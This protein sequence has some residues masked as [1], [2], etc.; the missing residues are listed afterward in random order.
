MLRKSG[1]DREQSNSWSNYFDKNYDKYGK[2]IEI[3]NAILPLASTIVGIATPFIISGYLSRKMHEGVKGSKIVKYDKDLEDMYSNI[4]VSKT[5]PTFTMKPDVF[6]AFFYG[7]QSTDEIPRIFRYIDFAGETNIKDKEEADRIRKG[8]MSLDL[9]DKIIRE[10]LIAS[11]PLAKTH[12]ILSHEAGHGLIEKSDEMP[13]VKF[14][15]RYLYGGPIQMLLKILATVYSSY[16][17][18]EIFREHGKIDIPK[19]L[20]YMFI[21]PLAS[22]G[23]IIPEYMASYIARKRHI[24][25]AD[26]SEKE[27]KKQKKLLRVAFATYLN[28]ALTFPVSALIIA[29]GS[30]LGH[31]LD[32]IITR[33]T[34]KR[35]AE[36]NKSR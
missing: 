28:K 13:M 21:P 7:P 35:I 16:K 29:A 20:P 12:G 1:Q 3:A 23:T 34:I 22:I 32:K 4:G 24:E 11:H 9:A 14:M 2:Y 5:L 19:S 6:N 26:I 15:Q 27:K 36:R 18:A 31:E 8:V 33:N 17:I 30:N 25:K 10:G